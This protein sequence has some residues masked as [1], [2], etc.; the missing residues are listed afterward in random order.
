MT[1]EESNA[2]CFE[3]EMM[4]TCVGNGCNRMTSSDKWICSQEAFEDTGKNE[5][6]RDNWGED[7]V[8]MACCSG[9]AAEKLKCASVKN[10]QFCNF[11]FHN[12]S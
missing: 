10:I 6:R 2:A 9:K 12:Y 5:D 11:M 1:G 4:G 8:V 7:D 3:A